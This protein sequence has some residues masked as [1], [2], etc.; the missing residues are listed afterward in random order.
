MALAKVKVLLT[1][2]VLRGLQPAPPGKRISIWDTAVPGLCVR[3]G[4]TG[5]AAFSLMFTPLGA[6]S[7]STRRAL[8]ISWRI[9]FPAGQELPYS[10]ATA[11]ADARAL[12]VN[13]AA[14]GH[15][16]SWAIARR[17]RELAESMANDFG[18]ES[19][20]SEGQRQLIHRATGLSILAENVEK[21]LVEGISF[22]TETYGILCDRLGRLFGRL[23][24][25]RRARNVTPT[26]SAYLEAVRAEPEG[27]AAE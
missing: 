12:L 1:D 5:Y 27:E 8:G 16:G 6:K 7:G 23:G 9:P 2:N 20:L 13:L 18:G 22:D 10:L 3:V 26:L 21:D 24:L 15:A 17:F 14:R 25:E 4:D 11:R 19:E